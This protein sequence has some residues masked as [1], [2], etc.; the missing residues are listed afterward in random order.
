MKLILDGSIQ[1]RID[2]HN[3]V[4]LAQ[5]GTNDPS[6]TSSM[7]RFVCQDVDQ[8]SQT[9]AKAVEMS[10]LYTRRWGTESSCQPLLLQGPHPSP[11]LR[12]PQGEHLGEVP[13]QG[14]G[15]PRKL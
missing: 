3:R 8:R 9:F 2:S 12:R 13:G 1:A 5:V 14:P 4:L 15:R 7:S 10:R 11:P 6:D